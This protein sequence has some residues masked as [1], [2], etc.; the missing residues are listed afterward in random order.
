MTTININN[1]TYKV[2]ELTP[3]S[4]FSNISK[5]NSNI[6]YFFIA[7]GKRGALID[8]HITKDGGVVVY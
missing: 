7:E 2:V 4:N 6:E 5:E 8:G 1:R 3:A